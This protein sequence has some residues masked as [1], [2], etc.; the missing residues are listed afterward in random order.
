MWKSDWH[1]RLKLAKLVSGLE[2][3][4]QARPRYELTTPTSRRLPVDFR[5]RP[6]LETETHTQMMSLEDYYKDCAVS[7]VQG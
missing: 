6:M 2:T 4:G 5:A 3:A 7:G 1:R